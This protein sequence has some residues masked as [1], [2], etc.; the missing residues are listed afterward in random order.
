MTAADNRPTPGR[1][2]GS[3]LEALLDEALLETF[4]A[5]DPVAIGHAQSA[6]SPHGGESEPLPGVQAPE[7]E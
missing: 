7:R 1:V 2:H 6:G 5:S 4:P 3:H